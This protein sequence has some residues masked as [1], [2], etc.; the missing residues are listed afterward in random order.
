LS[1]DRAVARN[2][3]W[4]EKKRGHRRTGSN[5]FGLAGELLFFA[6]LLVLGGIGLVAIVRLFVLPQWRVRNEFVETTCTVLDS[7]LQSDESGSLFRP[8]IEI[9]YKVDGVDYLAWTYDIA[10]AL[11]APSSYSNDKE[12]KQAVLGEFAQRERVPCWY[13]PDDPNVVVIERG[14]SWWVW[15]LFVIPLSFLLIGGG[16]ALYAVLHWGK[17]AERAASIAQRA[18]APQLLAGRGRSEKKHPFIPDGSDL[19]NS[20]GTR[21]AYRLPIG[22]SP[23]VAMLGTLLICLLW[24]GI[25]FV[26]IGLAIGGLL[27]GNPDWLLTLFVLPFFAVGVKLIVVFVRQ[28]LVTA[29]IGTTF[30]EISDHPLVPGKTY[31]LLISQ[32]GKLKIKKLNVS[33]ICEE[34][35]TYRQGTDTRAENRQ[36]F[37]QELFRRENF[38][39]QPGVP[40]EN[41][42][43]FRVPIGVMHSFKAAHNQISWKIQVDGEAAGWPDFKRAFP[44]IMYPANGQSNSHNSP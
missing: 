3:R 13:D 40:F 14:S 7:R 42:C 38:E 16:G 29:G 20:P 32:A 9:E 17:S 11:N 37:Q 28:M 41:Q 27:S 10:T 5:W 33:L 36:V 18:K 2:F 23:V 30:V 4:Y 43:D 21:L 44:V 8:E 26:Y 34:Q 39:V 1:G 24:N 35:A 6:A 31:S 15:L 19:T 12:G 25:V 22:T